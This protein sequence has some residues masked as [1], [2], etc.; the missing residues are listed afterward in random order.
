MLYF[1][2][3]TRRHCGTR[4]HGGVYQS[5][6]CPSQEIFTGHLYLPIQS[7]NFDPSNSPKITA[8]ADGKTAYIP[9]GLQK[10]VMLA[11]ARWALSIMRNDAA[12][13][14]FRRVFSKFILTT[15]PT[16]PSRRPRSGSTSSSACAHH[17]YEDPGKDIH[18]K[19]YSLSILSIQLR[20]CC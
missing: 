4:S 5:H 15:P 11:V 18:P 16:R 1:E 19:A 7:I 17:K 13:A 14:D 12:L 8:N 20:A 10:A 2:R 6:H 3:R 9:L